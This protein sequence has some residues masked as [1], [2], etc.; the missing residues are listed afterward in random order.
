MLERVHGWIGLILIERL[1]GWEGIICG[2]SAIYISPAGVL[3]EARGKKILACW[4][5]LPHPPV[6]Q[7]K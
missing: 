2:L 5:D 1:A 7:K 6:S 4:Q 3:S